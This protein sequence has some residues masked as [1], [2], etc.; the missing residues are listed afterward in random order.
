MCVTVVI[1]CY[2]G[3]AYLGAA[4]ESALAQT[5][6]PL[7]VL[8]IDDGSTD[9]SLD[10]ARSYGPPVRVISQSN[11]GES[12]ARNRGIDEARGDWI[13][14]LDADDVWRPQKL[15]RQLAMTAADVL[16]V[17]TN[18]YLF[19][20]RNKLFEFSHIPVAERYS[21]ER[22]FLGRSP[23]APSTI[24]VPK[25]LPVRFPV[26]TKY[27]EDTVYFVEIARLGRI[28]LVPEYLTGVRCH[29]ASQSRARG[30]VALWHATFTTWLQQHAGELDPQRVKSLQHRMLELVVHRAFQAYYRDD[31]E[32]YRLLC[33]Y[34]RQFDGDAAVQT[35]LHRPVPP[36]WYY[37]LRRG[38][39]KLH[40]SRSRAA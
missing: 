35:L 31:L 16:G 14:F 23:L 1:P 39:G 11:Q 5:H 33:D 3:A 15:Q 19:G 28:V 9:R 4:I 30:I 7:E 20:A 40:S 12:V 26:W 21:L 13:A 32:V 17:H 29:D 6:A 24:M 22:F 18:F 10:L 37:K 36:Q 38:L 34:L 8:V 2:N 27:A 25:W